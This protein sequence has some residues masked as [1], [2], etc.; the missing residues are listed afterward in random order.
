MKDYR[1]DNSIENETSIKTFNL[2]STSII[3]EE[4]NIQSESLSQRRQS[5]NFDANDLN[6]S[7]I[8]DKGNL[9]ATAVDISIS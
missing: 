9:G 4:M 2:N 3:K 5:V 8:R 1:Y 6:A 7:V